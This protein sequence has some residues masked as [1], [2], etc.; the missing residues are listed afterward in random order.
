VRNL[1]LTVQRSYPLVN[2]VVT[3]MVM[4]NVMPGGGVYVLRYGL[5]H[6]LPNERRELIQPLLFFFLRHLIQHLRIQILAS[7]SL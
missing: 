4:L 1:F 7:A 2:E 6:G 5:V 3:A